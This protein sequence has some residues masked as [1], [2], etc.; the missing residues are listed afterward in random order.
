MVVWGL[1]ENLPQGRLSQLIELQR[2]RGA[3]VFVIQA[4]HQF[5]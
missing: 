4:D 3:A 1:V 5:V 2:C